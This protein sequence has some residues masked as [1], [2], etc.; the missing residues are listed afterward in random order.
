MG[1]MRLTTRE[2]KVRDKTRR[3]EWKTVLNALRD[4]REKE[5]AKKHEWYLANKGKTKAR[6]IL[7]REE[8]RDYYKKWCIENKDKVKKIHAKW[9]KN[10]PDK[11]KENGTRWRKNNP[12][13]SNISW[14]NYHAR[15]LGN[16]G[17]LPV[18]IHKTLR[19]SQNN[20]CAICKK[21]I[22]TS[23]YHLDHIIPL[24]LGGR[25]EEGNVQLTCPIC[26]LKKG[27]KNPIQHKRQNGRAT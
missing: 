26:N 15:K 17:I 14:T 21:S 16:G 20:K 4:R 2:R 8:H 19:I 12:E 1:G 22:L 18:D 13:K 27:S 3:C 11:I 9:R 25:N 10:N 23:E 5:R 7:Y 24:V 6:D